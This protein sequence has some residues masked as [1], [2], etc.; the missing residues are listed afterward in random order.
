[1]NYCCI[2]L[3]ATHLV[4]LA[5]D[6]DRVHAADIGHTNVLVAQQ[7]VGSCRHAAYSDNRP[8][9]RR[10][11]TA[12]QPVEHALLLLLP[13]LHFKHQ[14]HT[15]LAVAGV[16]MVCSSLTQRNSAGGARLARAGPHNCA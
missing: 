5:V 4:L 13:L 1:M 3:H 2:C 14:S 16:I 10:M 9:K 15:W 11:V 8:W 6:G 12:K 7:V